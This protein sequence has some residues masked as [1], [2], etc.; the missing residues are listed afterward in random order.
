MCEMG[1][2]TFGLLGMKDLIIIQLCCL[3]RCETEVLNTLT[4]KADLIYL[5]LKASSLERENQKSKS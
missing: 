1:N 5:G 3:N 4:A 2:D